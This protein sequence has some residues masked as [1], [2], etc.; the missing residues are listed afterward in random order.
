MSD[1]Y[2]IAGSC[3]EC[4]APIYG[5]TT[6]T[7]QMIQN[8]GSFPAPIPN[9]IGAVYSCDCKKRRVEWEDDSRNE[10][11]VFHPQEDA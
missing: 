6:V 5:P 11:D 4:G 8:Y 3:P 10:R 7:P 1:V 2:T 9:Q